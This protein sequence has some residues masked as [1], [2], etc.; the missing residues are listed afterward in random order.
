MTIV[1][2]IHGRA[3]RDGE[4][5]ESPAGT[6]WCRLR[7]A[8][9]ARADRETNEPMTQWL[10]LVAFG[11]QA[12]ELAKVE[13]GQTLSAIGRVELNRW[14][15]QN[16]AE[17]QDLQLIA[18]AVVTARSSRPGGR[19]QKGSRQKEPDGEVPFDDAIVF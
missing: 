10:I 9:E 8:C 6:S 18:D 4:L 1:A 17:H 19:R 5:R 12:E 2:S 15:G 14:T 11:R 7:V 16:G 3:A 13:K